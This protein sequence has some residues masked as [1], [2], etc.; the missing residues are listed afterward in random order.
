MKVEKISAT[1]V[2]SID[3]E[4]HEVCLE[5]S[6]SV[7]RYANDSMALLLQKAMTRKATFIIK[8][9]SVSWVELEEEANSRSR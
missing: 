6:D 8:G 2:A 5:Y 4:K 9:Q 7:Y 3:T 1:Y